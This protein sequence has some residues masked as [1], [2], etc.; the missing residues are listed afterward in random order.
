[1]IGLH[2]FGKISLLILASPTLPAQSWKAELDA[3][4]LDSMRDWQVPGLAL[5]VVQNGETTFS[6]GYGVLEKGSPDLVNE[7]TLFAVGSTTKAMTAA[8]IGQLVDEG[9]LRWSDSVHQ[10]LPGFR[11]I[12][13]FATR[14]INIRDLLTH[15]AGLGNA[16]LL[17]Y[18]VDRNRR[19]ILDAVP[20]IPMAYSLRDGFVYQNI[21]YVVAGDL[22][23]RVAESS[24]ESLLQERLFKPLG[25]ARSTPTTTEALQASNVA[26][27]H[28][29]FASG[30]VAIENE[31]LDAV[32]PAGAVWSSVSEMSSW[33]RMLLAEG[34]HNNRRIL[35]AETATELLSPQTLLEI[36]DAYPH[37][38]LFKPNWISYALGWFQLD[39]RGRAISFHTGSI[40]GMSAI[41]GLV[42][43][44][45][46]GVVV[47]ANLDHAE[48]RHALLWKTFDLLG[49]EQSGPDWSTHLLEFYSQRADRIQEQRLQRKELRQVHTQPSLALPEY[50]G[51]YQNALYGKIE[52]RSEP[53]G[54]RFVAGL[55]RQGGLQHWH[56]DTF[57]IEFDRPWQSKM[58]LNFHLDTTGHPSSLEFGQAVFK[59]ISKE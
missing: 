42:P 55:R 31:I 11:T 19:E 17:W 50:S 37:L 28:Y 23:G 24:W 48:L 41:V 8:L 45:N 5:A 34:V 35:R 30:I 36:G 58:L 46:L 39:Y 13:P 32:A 21:M 57:E 15:R 22:T 33:I 59:R 29:R 26:R 43:R 18:G 9:K 51:H 40:D 4:V 56:F 44:E 14:E 7:H 10:H 54:L 16:D 3:Y 52:I 49:P 47:L 20:H 12:D 38:S 25:M 53:Q 1:M 27:P 2:P 6:K